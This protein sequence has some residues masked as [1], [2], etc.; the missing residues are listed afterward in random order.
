MD[1][2]QGEAIQAFQTAESTLH[3]L[4][5]SITSLQAVSNQLQSAGRTLEGTGERVS[6]ASSALTS[7][8]TSLTQLSSNLKLIVDTLG[9][10]EPDR[11]MLE[12]DNLRTQVQALDATT[13]AEH[14][15]SV[16]RLLADMVNSK[17]ELNETIEQ[18]TEGVKAKVSHSHVVLASRFDRIAKQQPWILTFCIL[19]ALLAAGC[20]ALIARG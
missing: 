9:R 6:E 15:A 13:K 5:T 3:E 8:A 2:W 1:D 14:A 12:I 7:V 19:T 4:S 10:V 18:A 16:D 17:L 11:I 20:L